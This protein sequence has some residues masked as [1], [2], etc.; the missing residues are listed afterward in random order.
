MDNSNPFVYINDI[1]PDNYNGELALGMASHEDGVDLKGYVHEFPKPPWWDDEK[2]QKVKEEYVGHHR[3]CRRKAVESGFSDLPPAE[4]GLYQRHDVPESG[5][6]DDTEPIG[7]TGT[8]T[9]VAAAREASREKPLVVVIGGPLS[10]V[11]DAYLV[12]PSIRDKIVVF[13]RFRRDIDGWNE[14]L[15]GWSATVATRRLRTVFCPASGGPLLKRSAVKRRLPDE[16]LKEYMLTK[17]YDGTSENPLSSGEKWEGDAVT[18]L[19]A[20]HPETRGSTEFLRFDGL[21][22]H[23]ALGKVLPSFLTTT[24]PTSTMVIPEHRHE[25]MNAAWWGHMAGPTT[26]GR[27]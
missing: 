21:K 23:W 16:P 19:S 24:E 8:R 4:C 5:S 15:S 17:V 1:P 18:T 25:E 3:Q 2:Y 14:F 27:E 6:I 20:A 26:W 7:S 22:T 10:T 9:I 11:A 12:D 13:C